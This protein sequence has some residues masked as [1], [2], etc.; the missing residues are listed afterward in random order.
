MNT[1]IAFGDGHLLNGNLVKRKERYLRLVN[2]KKTQLDGYIRLRNYHT[3]RADKENFEKYSDLILT[4]FVSKN[5]YKVF[6]RAIKKIVY[7]YSCF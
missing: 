3:Y 4:E 6:R 1:D 5:D 2:S 7:A